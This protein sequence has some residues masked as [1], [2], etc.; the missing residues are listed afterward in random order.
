[1][2]II[3]GGVNTVACYRLSLAH[4]NLDNE[5]EFLRHEI[6]SRLLVS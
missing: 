5:T 1:M 2:K 3:F 4:R 6:T